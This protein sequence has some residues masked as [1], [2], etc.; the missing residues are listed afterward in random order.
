MQK[1]RPQFDAKGKQVPT[2]LTGNRT[3]TYDE[4]TKKWTVTDSKTGKVEEMT[5]KELLHA[6]QALK[7]VVQPIV[8]RYDA[9]GKQIPI[10]LS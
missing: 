7:T 1:I 4:S 2:K 5:H 8:P 6:E 3:G 9:N 10:Q